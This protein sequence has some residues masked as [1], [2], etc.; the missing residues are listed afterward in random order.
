MEETRKLWL[1]L[2]ALLL[3]EQNGADDE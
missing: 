1:E 2:V 3:A